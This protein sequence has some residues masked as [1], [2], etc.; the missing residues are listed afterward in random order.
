[1]SGYED[2]SYTDQT[3]LKKQ[4]HLDDATRQE[5]RPNQ[6]IHDIFRCLL[7]TV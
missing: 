3:P 7:V 2:P 4:P 6:W 5:S 1:M